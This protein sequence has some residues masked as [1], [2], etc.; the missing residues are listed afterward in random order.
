M[1]NRTAYRVV[2]LGVYCIALDQVKARA[3]FA[4]TSGVMTSQIELIP[5]L[6]KNGPRKE[7]SVNAKHSMVEFEIYFGGSA[8]DEPKYTFE[9]IS[10]SL[11]VVQ[12]HGK[13]Y[14][15]GKRYGW[16]QGLNQRTSSGEIYSCGNQEVS[17]RL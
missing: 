3:T 13:C 4:D 11:H 10:D 14:R 7:S 15:H 5:R 12:E 2:V 17:E 6:S 8:C 16:S 1:A 9:K